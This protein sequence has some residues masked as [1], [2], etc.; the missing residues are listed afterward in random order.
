MSRR[1]DLH[2]AFSA[3][4]Q[5]LRTGPWG[6]T[7]NSVNTYIC[8]AINSAL[9]AGKISWRQSDMAVK[10]I[11]YRLGSWPDGEARTTVDEFIEYSIGR[12]ALDRARRRDPDC[13]QVYRHRW[14]HALIAEFSK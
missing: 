3:A 12:H 4:E 13:M 2:A 8:H 1:S 7:R 6:P 10:L 14:L 5:Y 11:Q 9:T